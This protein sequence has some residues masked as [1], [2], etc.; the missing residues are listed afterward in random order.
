MKSTEL[1]K[2][3]TEVRRSLQELMGL[4]EP[5]RII[6]T[7]GVLVAL[8]LLFASLGVRKLA[9]SSE[10]YYSPL[11]FP[12]I[13]TQT[14][15]PHN[16]SEGI[17]SFQ[18]DAAIVSAVTWKG[19]VLWSHSLFSEIK[20]R[21]G[22]L[23][24]DCTHIGA[25]GFID[26]EQ[27]PADLLCSDAGKWIVP[28]NWTERL[29]FLYP[30]TPVMRERCQTTFGGFF[31]ASSEQ[32]DKELISANWVSPAGLQLYATYLSQIRRP[33]L[34]ASHV[35][36]L[37]FALHVSR[38]FKNSRHDPNCAIVYLPAT[39]GF[40]QLLTELTNC[41]LAWHIDGGVRITCRSHEYERSRTP[42]LSPSAGTL[43]EPR[44]VG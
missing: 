19:R 23:V 5:D 40:D 30:Q 15:E 12:G 43:G 36:N 6:L 41:H 10:E 31:L 37:G 9:M 29:A 25:I 38:R 8:R 22:L 2:Q 20:K 33:Q 39:P 14:F 24:A 44:F 27:M 4:G 42:L 17:A 16:L 32:R 21:V 3:A 35:A 1:P 18:P 26:M 13:E 34:L 11:H 7:P 28:G